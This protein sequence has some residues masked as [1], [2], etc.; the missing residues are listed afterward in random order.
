M[1]Y[2]QTGGDVRGTSA[3]LDYLDTEGFVGTIDDA[4][5]QAR[6]RPDFGL[7]APGNER[8]ELLRFLR[9]EPK[10]VAAYADWLVKL[11]QRMEAEHERDT[12]SD[13]IDMRPEPVD[14]HAHLGKYS[15][16]YAIARG[17]IVPVVRP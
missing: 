10:P 2:A 3:D 7:K 5:A 15:L 12:L 14:P 13:W 8:D 6:A 11:M 4:I 16:A 9:V 1:K 17:W